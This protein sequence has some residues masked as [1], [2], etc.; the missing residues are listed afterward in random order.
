[1]GHFPSL[2]TS[3]GSVITVA[4][5]TATLVNKRRSETVVRGS[6]TAASISI[7]LQ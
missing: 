4:T 7:L 3:L 6:G 5:V 2:F 1:M